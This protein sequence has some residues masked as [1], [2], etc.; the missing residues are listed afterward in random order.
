MPRRKPKHGWDPGQSGN[1]SGRPKGTPNR[2]V[3]TE[4][5]REAFALLLENNVS[6]LEDWLGKLAKKNPEK[7]LE[8]YVKI[9]ER[10]VPMLSRTEITSKDGEPFTPIT[11]NLPSLP[12]IS[13]P[14]SIGEGAP[15]PLLASPAEEVKE[16]GEG[17]ATEFILPKPVLTQNILRD[18]REMG[19][20]PP[21][22][23]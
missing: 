14:T 18:L 1:P 3:I 5:I 8:M 4:R 15:I 7:A 2:V 11:I 13:V 9:S 22:E 21:E 23:L 6:E 20:E 19:I 12:Q 16:I 17:A 10:F